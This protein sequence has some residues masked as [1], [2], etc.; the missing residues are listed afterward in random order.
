[1]PRGR[2]V[3]SE[4]RQNIV[5]I[6]YFLGEGYGYD[7]YRIYKALFPKCTS[8]VIYYHLR[9]GTKT[10]EFVIKTIKKEKGNYSWGPMAEKIYYELGPDAS[11]R[12]KKEVKEYI[13][14]LKKERE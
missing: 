4:I 6:L 7:I 8:E 11:P 3:G 2:P 5:D 12:L 1:M 13:L 14:K 9:K 10:G